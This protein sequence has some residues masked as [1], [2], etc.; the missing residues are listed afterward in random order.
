MVQGFY[1]VEVLHAGAWVFSRA[2]TRKAP[3]VKWAKRHGGR[4]TPPA[5]RSAA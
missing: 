4:V 5:A 1:A 3:A 2:F